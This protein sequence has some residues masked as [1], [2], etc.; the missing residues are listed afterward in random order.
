MSPSQARSPSTIYSP[1][2][3]PSAST[4]RAS[5]AITS[6]KPTLTVALQQAQAAVVLDAA[7]DVP[8]AILA[9]TKSVELLNEVMDKVQQGCRRDQELAARLE[10][11]LSPASRK[12]KGR[13]EDPATVLAESDRLRRYE[14]AEKKWR[15]KLEEGRRLRVI[16]SAKELSC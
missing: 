16:V 3:S 8:A 6:T 7:N 13:E 5:P 4:L 12:G 9:Y 14:R 2:T 11:P 1:G 10:A 15:A